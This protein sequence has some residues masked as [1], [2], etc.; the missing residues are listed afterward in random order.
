MLYF[1][2]TTNTC[3]PTNITILQ[4]RGLSVFVWQ[5][6]IAEGVRWSDLTTRLVITRFSRESTLD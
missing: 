1:G 6:S 2:R 5:N 4:C 3:R